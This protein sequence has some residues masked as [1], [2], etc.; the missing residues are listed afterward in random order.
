[1]GTGWCRALPGVGLRWAVGLGCQPARD[2]GQDHLHLEMAH[3]ISRYMLLVRI[4]HM[5]F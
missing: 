5:R 4:G 1:M 2:P 3:L